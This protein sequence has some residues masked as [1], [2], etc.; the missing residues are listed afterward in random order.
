MNMLGL[1]RTQLSIEFFP[2][3]GGRES[4]GVDGASV[5]HTLSLID[6]SCD[7]GFAVTMRRPCRHEQQ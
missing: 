3:D 4:C 7:C 6:W 2:V 5:A 1:S